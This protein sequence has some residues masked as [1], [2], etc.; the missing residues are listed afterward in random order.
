[1]LQQRHQL[2]NTTLWLENKFSPAGAAKELHDALVALWV[3]VE[4]LE[5]E[6]R[7]HGIGL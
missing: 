6:V 5:R 7:E 3:H 1:M 2:L 4:N